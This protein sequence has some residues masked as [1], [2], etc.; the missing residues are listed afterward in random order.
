MKTKLKSEVEETYPER[1]KCTRLQCGVR[2]GCRAQ[3]HGHPALA[4]GQPQLIRAGLH[5]AAQG[6]D[7]GVRAVWVEMRRLHNRYYSAIQIH[8]G[9]SYQWPNTPRFKLR[10]AHQE[11]QV[12][13]ADAFRRGGARHHGLRLEHGVEGERLGTLNATL[14]HEWVVQLINQP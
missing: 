2:C 13:Q 10:M 14:S 5:Q 1:D 12:L 7:L 4:P 9:P 8:H 3:S 6:E 11:L